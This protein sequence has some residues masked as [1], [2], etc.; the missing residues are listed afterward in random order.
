ME[1]IKLIGIVII[2]DGF[3]YKLDTIA[4]VIFARLVSGLVAGV[5]LIE[6]LEMIGR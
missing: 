1:W 4:T 2:V 5:Y 3:I 6:F